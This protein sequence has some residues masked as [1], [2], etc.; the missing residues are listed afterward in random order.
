MANTI[1]TD[2]LTLLQKA[3]ADLESITVK[4]FLERSTSTYTVARTHRTMA[5]TT[6]LVEIS[7]ASYARQTVTGKAVTTDDT[8]HWSMF[9]C[10]DVDFGVLVAG[11]EV[12]A[13]WFIQQI[14]G[15]PASGDKLLARFDTL[16]GLPA[17]LA[18]N[19]FL[20]PIPSMGLWVLRQAA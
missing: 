17:T 2:A 16:S 14:G 4:C 7:V 12:K 11:Q 10:D 20:V 8:N 15:S 3:D 5:D 1:F 19:D 18:D 6:G 9:D 13:V